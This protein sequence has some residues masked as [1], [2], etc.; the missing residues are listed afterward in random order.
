MLASFETGFGSFHAEGKGTRTGRGGAQGISAVSERALVDPPA[1]MTSSR[2]G[3]ATSACECGHVAAASLLSAQV[4]APFESADHSGTAHAREGGMKRLAT[5]HRT[6]PARIEAWLTRAARRLWWLIADLSRLWQGAPE[7]RI[8]PR[9]LNAELRRGALAGLDDD[10]FYC[11]RVKRRMR[12]GARCAYPPLI[13][14]SRPRSF[15]V[16]RQGGWMSRPT[17]VSAR[18]PR[19]PLVEWYGL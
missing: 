2:R 16:F 4:F 17:T 19:T 12:D 8:D 13:D 10:V 6:L 3:F 11:E 15:E 1:L 14:R 18:S 7:L 9:R 5:S